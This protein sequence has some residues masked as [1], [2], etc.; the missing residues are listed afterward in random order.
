V[1]GA[2]ESLPDAFRE[3]AAVDEVLLAEREQIAAVGPL[4]RRRQTEEEARPEVVYQPAVGGA[5][6]WWNSSTTM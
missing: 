4:R 6:A 3:V 5:E 2:Q 1:K